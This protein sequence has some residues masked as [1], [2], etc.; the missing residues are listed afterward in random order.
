M[1]TK[2]SAEQILA[3]AFVGKKFIGS[4][5][6]DVEGVL[7][8]SNNNQTDVKPKDLIGKTIKGSYTSVYSNAGCGIA[9]KF[10]G[11]DDWFFFFD[12][13]TITVED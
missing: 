2:Q 10:E 6:Y 3:K 7:Y 11:F 12:N 8:D 13:D 1:Q 5:F 9:L 4:D